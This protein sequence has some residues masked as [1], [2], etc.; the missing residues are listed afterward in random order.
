[1]NIAFGSSLTAAYQNCSDLQA[2]AI[3]DKAQIDS[4]GQQPS[5]EYTPSQPVDN[6]AARNTCISQAAQ[7]EQLSITNIMGTYGQSPESDVLI[8]QAQGRY[9][10]DVTTCYQLYP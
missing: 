6:S 5:A 7:K 9:N 1:M 4:L 8:T 3:H 2:K 10:N